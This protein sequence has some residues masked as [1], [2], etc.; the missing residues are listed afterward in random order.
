MATVDDVDQLIEHYQLGL[1]EFVKGNPEAVKKLF[2]HRDDVTLAN[3]RG[4]IA[5]GWEQVAKRMKDV[6]SGRREGEASFEIVEKF[7]SPELACVVE[8]ERAQAKFGAREDVTSYALRATIL[9]R[10]EDGT[11]K[12]AHRH[13]DPISSVQQVASYEVE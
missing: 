5:H 6:A 2:S 1:E 10:R 13:A 3:P 11:W 12:V 8:M 7:V 4:G 9:F